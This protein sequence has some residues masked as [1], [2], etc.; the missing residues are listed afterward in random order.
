MKN[1]L[2]ENMLRF[3]T[4]NLSDSAQKELIVKSIMQTI[5]EHGLN[6]AVYRRL[7]TEQLETVDLI[8]DPLA[9]A[10][11]KSLKLQYKQGTKLPTAVMGHYYLKS[12]DEITST[13]DSTIP[14]VRG[15][16]GRLIGKGIGGV[17]TIP[18]PANFTLG[19][20]GPMEFQPGGKFLI[21]QFDPASK[22]PLAG[23][24][25]DAAAAINQACA[26][27]TLPA[28]QSMLAADPKKPAYDTAIA[29]FKVSK[30][31]IKALLT[32]NAKAFYGV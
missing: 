5:N 2:S 13:P 8:A 17:G 11:I 23:V 22:L 25:A 19:E 28:L 20:G 4:K 24:A 32:G 31:A 18:V 21:L 3:G 9:A 7:L 30:S 1:L 10:A 6:N 12:M 16:V 29:A 27:Y 15:R 14:V 26:L